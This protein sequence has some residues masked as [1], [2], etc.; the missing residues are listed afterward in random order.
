ME[1]TKTTK[2][3]MTERDRT[4]LQIASDRFGTTTLEARGTDALDFYDCAVWNIRLA[5]Q[6]A[7]EAGRKSSR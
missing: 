5:L 7:Y 4:L 6:A 1:T 3:K 2:K